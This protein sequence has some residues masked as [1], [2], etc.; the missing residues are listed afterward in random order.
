MRI[1]HYGL[2]WKPELVKTWTQNGML[3][4]EKGDIKKGP[5]AFGGKKGLYVLH[6]NYRVVYVGISGRGKDQRLGGRI[7]YQFE[8]GMPGRW[9]AFSWFAIA[10]NDDDKTADVSF[11]ETLKTLEGLAIMI[12]QPPLNRA[13]PKF[14]H[15]PKE[16]RQYI[17]K[18]TKDLLKMTST[19]EK[20][21]LSELHDKLLRT[22]K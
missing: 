15:K 18:Q 5:E 9:D 3:G 17:D 22:H 14:S 16:I 19:E 10:E 20:R 2:F 4:L 7:Q 11:E 1:T 6:Q 12:A 21:L 8:Q 13:Q